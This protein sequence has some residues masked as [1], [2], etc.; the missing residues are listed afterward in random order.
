M[1]EQSPTR[2][3]EKD[4]AA[5]ERLRS[6][7]IE[8]LLKEPIA[9][10]PLSVRAAAYC[11]RKNLTTIGHLAQAK[12]SEMLK[13]RNMGHRTVE[14]IKA[15]LSHLGLG[16]DGKLA[17]TLPAPMPPAYARGAQAMKA[18]IIAQ[19][20]VLNASHEL[21]L[22]VSKLPLPKPEDD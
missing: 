17:A 11:A 22:A 21:V 13:A 14:H 19:L 7:P 9:S 6:L 5:F 8:Q 3:Y 15:Y 4:R 12:R 2:I 16:L 20:A 1:S 18:N 10:L